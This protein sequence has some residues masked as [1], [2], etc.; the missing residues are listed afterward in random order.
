MEEQKF[1]TRY[2]WYFPLAIIVTLLVGILTSIFIFH[3]I[4]TSNRNLL[5]Y[6]T[7]TIA[8]A[9]DVKDIEA[10]KGD[11]S[12]L[13]RPEYKK[14][15]SALTSFRAVNP[16]SRFVYV[17]G[18]RPTGVIFFY[19]DSEDPESEDYSPPGE[20]YYEE[21][22]AFDLAFEGKSSTEGPISDRW[23]RWISGAGAI[24]DESGQVQAVAGIDIDATLYIQT[25]LAF[26]SIP[27][28]VAICFALFAFAGMKM[29]KQE[30]HIY[31]LKAQ[32]VAIAS[33]ELRS[34]LTGVRWAILTL[35]KEQIIE[36]HKKT[37]RGMLESVEKLNQTINDILNASSYD[38]KHPL[39]NVA[40]LSLR[41][42]LDSAL[43]DLSMTAKEKD[44]S[45]NGIEKIPSNFLI[46]GEVSALSQ[47][48]NNVISNAIKYSNEKSTVDIVVEE[49]KDML[50]LSVQDHGIGIPKDEI[51]KIYDGFYRASNAKKL[52]INGS[53]LGL[54]LVKKI[55][56]AHKG[57]IAIESAK[58]EGTI[59]R[60]C[61]PQAKQL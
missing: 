50:C 12:D 59:V 37:L 22:K 32:F 57:T 34:P 46:K 53:G 6:R 23:G 24:V 45:I 3:K 10:L 28:I 55:V 20:V 38:S 51:S 43:Q 8:K 40:P 41:S 54:Y 14:I 56:E 60:I 7:D 21:S 19:A 4:D 16:D 18:K 42:L 35:L 44:V 26:A 27:L 47:V 31:E 2:K 61:L 25:S 30:E 58:G 39:L 17:V 9:I 33:H 52:N 13:D 48:V 15:K 11:E 49:K 36:A 5:I 29:R 1:S